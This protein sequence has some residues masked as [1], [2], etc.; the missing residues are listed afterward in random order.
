PRNIHTLTTEEVSAAARARARHVQRGLD[1][2]AQRAV[3]LHDVEDA[4]LRRGRP[5]QLRGVGI[6]SS[7][8]ASKFAVSPAKWGKKL[9]FT[10]AEDEEPVAG[11]TAG[12]GASEKAPAATPATKPHTDSPA[13]G[14]HD[15]DDDM[16]DNEADDGLHY[17]LLPQPIEIIPMHDDV[18]ESI[19]RTS[20]PGGS[21]SA[22]TSDSVEETVYE[23]GIPVWTSESANS[24]QQHGT[25]R[26]RAAAEEQAQADGTSEA[27]SDGDTASESP[28]DTPSKQLLESQ[29]LY[30]DV[31]DASASASADEEDD[32]VEEEAGELDDIGAPDSY[33]VDDHVSPALK[34][35]KRVRFDHSPQDTPSKLRAKRAMQDSF[36]AVPHAD[37]DADADADAAPRPAVSTPTRKRQIGVHYD[38][39]ATPPRF[40]TGGAVLDFGPAKMSFT[41]GPD[42]GI[43]GEERRQKTGADTSRLEGP[44]V[45]RAGDLTDDIEYAPGPREVFEVKK[46]NQNSFGSD[47]LDSDSDSEREREGVHPALDDL[48][49]AELKLETAPPR[50]TR[51]TK[52]AARPAGEKEEEVGRTA[53]LFSQSFNS[54]ML[55][56]QKPLF[57]AA[58]GS[59]ST[60]TDGDALTTHEAP[61]TPKKRAPADTA[62]PAT[63]PLFASPSAPAPLN[64]T[65]NAGMTPGRHDPAYLE[66]ISKMRENAEKYKPK[67]SSGLRMSS[68]TPEERDEAKTAASAPAAAATAA[69]ATRASADAAAVITS[70]DEVARGEVPEKYGEWKAEYLSLDWPAPKAYAEMVEGTATPTSTSSEEPSSSSPTTAAPA[71]QSL[72]ELVN[73]YWTEEDSE[74]AYELFN[75]EYS[76]FLQEKAAAG[77]E[78]ADSSEDDQSS[79]EDDAG[80]PGQYTQVSI[81]A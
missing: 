54:S 20:S 12:D 14:P 10:Q 49:D 32:E 53:S 25:K 74:A 75:K 16:G 4:V 56:S 40:S 69:P 31:E 67:K 26:K 41:A 48:D 23:N 47:G 73:R 17:S 81:A 36:Y 30:P 57:G 35:I 21:P 76:R 22:P 68:E 65:V 44:A 51:S 38:D 42:F 9:S 5:V 28:H 70:Q 34:R 13:A 46:P 58:G 29:A 80:A 45:S 62:A 63:P 3:P 77:A 52:A 39:L 43:R 61:S 64:F 18:L 7:K 60:M 37:A 79:S 59:G 6:S 15:H 50:S 11:A 2:H 33:D 72:T 27:A 78:D 1:L 8:W 19:E 66:K 71:E 24:A 55:R